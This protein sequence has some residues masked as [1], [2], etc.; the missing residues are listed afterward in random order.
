MLLVKNVYYQGSCMWIRSPW[1]N[2]CKRQ[3][4]FFVFYVMILESLVPVIQFSHKVWTLSIA[5]LPF[6]GF[7]GM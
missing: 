1:H 3:N 2:S 7:A 5:V 4:Y 6:P